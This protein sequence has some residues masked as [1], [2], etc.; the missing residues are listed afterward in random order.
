[1]A[2]SAYVC[3]LNKREF[4]LPRTPKRLV[5]DTEPRR[6]ETGCKTPQTMPEKARSDA[7]AT[8]R[9]R[10]RECATTV[11]TL[12]V[13]RS[14]KRRLEGDAGVTTTSE[15][16]SQRGDGPRSLTVRT[17]KDSK[18]PKQH[19]QQQQNQKPVLLNESSYWLAVQRFSQL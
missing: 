1:M 7:T 15:K 16:R 9:N 5:S 6:E 17:A 4:K 18:R 14:L 3:W 10:P 12:S 8:A 2:P 19:K 13:L 11:S